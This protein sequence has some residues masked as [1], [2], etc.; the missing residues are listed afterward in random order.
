M[1][2]KLYGLLYVLFSCVLSVLTYVV[3]IATCVG[4]TFIVLRLTNAP[5]SIFSFALFFA[6]TVGIIVSVVIYTKLTKYIIKKINLAEKIKPA[7]KKEENKRK[8]VLP[9]S[10][11]EAQPDDK[12]RE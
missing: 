8:T 10:A 11:F 4:L 2:N 12:W 9:D 1:N 6:F 3:S 5:V 7:K